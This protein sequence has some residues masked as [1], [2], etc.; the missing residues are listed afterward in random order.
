MQMDLLYAEKQEHNNYTVR[1]NLEDI[2][3]QRVSM[4]WCAFASAV[5]PGH[6]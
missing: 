5:K 4:G 3:G 2:H 6:G 1:G